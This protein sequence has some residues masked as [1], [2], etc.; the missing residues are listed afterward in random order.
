MSVNYDISKVPF[1]RFGSYFSL[2]TNSWGPLGTAL[3][4]QLHYGKTAT[5]FRIDPVRDGKILEYEVETSPSLLKLRESG[6][7]EIEFALAG[8]G[9]LRLRGR[10]VSLRLEMPPERWTLT[11]AKPSSSST[12]ISVD[13]MPSVPGLAVDSN[14]R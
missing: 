1:S 7:G 10:G 12:L 5:A 8:Q 2:S 11:K 14:S 9:T 6:G 13:C 4:L 3:Y